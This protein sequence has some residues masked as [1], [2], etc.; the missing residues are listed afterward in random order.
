MTFIIETNKKTKAVP[1]IAPL[2]CQFWRGVIFGT[3]L[4]DKMNAC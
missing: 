4:F 1:N 2:L 3:A